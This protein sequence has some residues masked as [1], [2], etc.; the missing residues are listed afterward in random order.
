MFLSLARPFDFSLFD[1]ANN[2]ELQESSE[3]STLTLELPGY[4]PE[5][6]E[7]SVE[8]SLLKIRATR[9]NTE[10]RR[11]YNLSNRIRKEAIEAKVEHG[12]LTITLPVAEDQQARKIPVRAA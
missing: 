4:K 12:L 1:Y 3:A 7:V 9:A 2:S 5:D 6:I 10:F 8:G 11:T